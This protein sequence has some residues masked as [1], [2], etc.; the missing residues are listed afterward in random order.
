VVDCDLSWT[1]FYGAF[2]QTKSL[3]TDYENVIRLQE[4]IKDDNVKRIG[5]KNLFNPIL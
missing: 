1:L 3:F 2:E 5:G 4:A